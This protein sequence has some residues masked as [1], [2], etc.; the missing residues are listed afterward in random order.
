MRR[1]VLMLLFVALGGLSACCK[2][3]GSRASVCFPR[4]A[5]AGTAIVCDMEK[6]R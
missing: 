2:V 6:P 5:L 1:Y 3:F 4:P